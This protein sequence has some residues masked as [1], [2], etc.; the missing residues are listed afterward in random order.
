MLGYLQRRNNQKDIIL[1]AV[2]NKRVGLLL[3][4]LSKGFFPK[5]KNFPDTA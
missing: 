4:I 2:Q 5:T 1:K 3:Y